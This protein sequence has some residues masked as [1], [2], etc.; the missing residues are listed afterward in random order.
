[1]KVVKSN[2]IMAGVLAAALLLGGV[3]IARHRQTAV[4]PPPA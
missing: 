1:M 4:L 2:V 3:P